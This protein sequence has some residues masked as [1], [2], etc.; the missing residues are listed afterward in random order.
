M[1]AKII[2]GQKNLEF[3]SHNLIITSKC[4]IGEATRTSPHCV[5][6]FK[7]SNETAVKPF[8]DVKLFLNS[9]PDQVGMIN[10]KNIVIYLLPNCEEATKMYPQLKESNIVAICHTPESMKGIRGKKENKLEEK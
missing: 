7:P 4:P 6:V 9:T 8:K 3:E 5:I 1:D 2:E 10:G